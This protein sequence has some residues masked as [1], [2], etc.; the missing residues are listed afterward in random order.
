MQQGFLPFFIFNDEEYT[1]I[2]LSSPEE[3]QQKFSDLIDSYSKTIY[4]L[5][6]AQNL[7]MEKHETMWREM[8]GCPIM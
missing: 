4:K 8:P 3:F 7:P 2:V 6:D 1:D 5:I